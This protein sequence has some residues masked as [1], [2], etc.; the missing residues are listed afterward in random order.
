M[1]M[2]VSRSPPSQDWRDYRANDQAF[3]GFAGVVADFAHLVN[4]IDLADS[5]T[6][7]GKCI[8]SFRGERELTSS[9]QMAERESRDLIPF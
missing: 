4:G 9:S 2:L 7:D 6:L 8:T 1:L 5:L 3:G